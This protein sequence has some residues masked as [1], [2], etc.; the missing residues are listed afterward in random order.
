MQNKNG[1]IPDIFYRI[2]SSGFTRFTLDVENEREDER[3][4]LFW[5]K[6]LE[7]CGCINSD[8][9]TLGGVRL[10]DWNIKSSVFMCGV[11]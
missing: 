9:M 2:L 1:E 11:Y 8:A 5:S 4:P 10:G 3:W 7:P 6:Q